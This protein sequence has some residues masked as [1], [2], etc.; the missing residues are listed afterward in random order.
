[1]R[2][3]LS[4]GAGGKATQDM[5]QKLILSLL[6]EDMKRVEGGV[7]TDELDDGATL[8]AG[9]NHLVMSVDSYTVNPPF[10]PGGN[11]GVLAASG[12]INDVLMMGAK[13]VAAMDS[14]I[15]QE[16]F[17]LEEL[18]KITSSM[19]QVFRENGVK[20]VGGDF[21][22]MPFGDLRGVVITTVGVGWAEK[23][24]LDSSLKPGDKLLVTGTV[25][26]HGAAILAAQQGIEG[27]ESDVKPLTQVMLPLLE[28]FGDQ[29]RAAQDPTRGGLAQVLNEWAS[30]TGL[31]I[32][33]R[34][35]S[36]PIA[37]EVKALSEL[38]GVDPLQ[39]ASEGKAVLGVS[40]EVSEDVLNFLKERGCDRASIIGEV[41]ESSKYRGMVILETKVGG[42][43][44][45]ERPLGAV[46]PRIC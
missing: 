41:K 34:E 26:D 36:I 13:P 31:L 43:R 39:L 5:V 25:G 8:P 1:M 45:M 18:K 44:V 10:F 12:T 2:V 23:P 35:E 6:D 42:L 40:P 4:H 3:N 46:V 11:L 24:I 21:K 15:V 20:L 30:K 19:I 9:E 37:E 32:T 17:E 27:V 14:I 7:G 38:L 22:V 16:G 28:E 33:V 29:I